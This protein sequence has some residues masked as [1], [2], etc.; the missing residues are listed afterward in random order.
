MAV[1]LPGPAPINGGPSELSLFSI[2][3]IDFPTL[4]D[5][6]LL[7]LSAPWL[8]VACPLQNVHSYPGCPAGRGGAR[9]R[10]SCLKLTELR[11]DLPFGQSSPPVQPPGPFEALASVMGGPLRLGIRNPSFC[12]LEPLSWKRSAL[13]SSGLPKRAVLPVFSSTIMS[14]V[15]HAPPGPCKEAH[16]VCLA[17]V[18][19]DD[20]ARWA[21]R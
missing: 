2:S 15:S 14:C 5:C 18:G 9:G 6:S 10:P 4:P 20:D 16:L 19:L 1:P 11:F 13:R 3:R 17:S 7:V 21:H 8:A 12:P